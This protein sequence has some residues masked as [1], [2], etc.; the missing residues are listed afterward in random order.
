MR[1]FMNQRRPDNYCAS[2]NTTHNTRPPKCITIDPIKRK[3]DV[4]DSFRRETRALLARKLT[5]SRSLDTYR[6]EAL[7]IACLANAT[8]S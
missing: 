2:N 4:H 1:P 8:I 6:N 3:Y 5:H 7:Y